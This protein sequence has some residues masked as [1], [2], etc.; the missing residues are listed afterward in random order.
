MRLEC[1]SEQQY[2]KFGRETIEKERVKVKA[3]AVQSQN[4][5][6]FKKKRI[7]KNIAILIRRS[8]QFESSSKKRKCFEAIRD[9]G[10]QDR[11][12][13]LAVSNVLTKSMLSHGFENVKQHSRLKF[14]NQLKYRHINQMILRFMKVNMNE[15]FGRW[16]EVA[17]MRVNQTYAETKASYE[18]AV[19]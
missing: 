11:A 8:Q 6:E 16:K 3:R 5:A 14:L 1:E 12:F 13:V 7:D 2:I 15:F 9:I 10:K 19:L 18:E 17:R 4:H